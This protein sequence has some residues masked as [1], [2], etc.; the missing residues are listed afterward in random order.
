MTYVE[1]KGVIV[2]VSQEGDVSRGC[3]RFDRMDLGPIAPAGL[4][5]D[6]K[7][8]NERFQLH[9]LAG[10]D[11]ELFYFETYNSTHPLP[12]QGEVYSYRG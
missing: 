3:V 7:T 1:P 11:G 2:A 12:M 10:N 5:V 4:Y 8:G 6:P 9:K